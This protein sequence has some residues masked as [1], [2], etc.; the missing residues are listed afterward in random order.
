MNM[1]TRKGNLRQYQSIPDNKVM[2]LFDKGYKAKPVI[3]KAG[4]VLLIDTAK[5]IHRARPCTEGQR[6]ALTA[7][8]RTGEGYHDYDV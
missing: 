2:P 5:L 8:Y 4:T 6:Y 3:V 7:Y 1:F